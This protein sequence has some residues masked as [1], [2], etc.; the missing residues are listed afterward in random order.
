MANVLK[1]LFRGAATT[2]SSTLYTVPASTT[3][4][5]SAILVS[6][7]SA[8]AQ[9]YT[10]NIDDVPIATTVSVSAN[11]SIMFEPKQAILA[12]GTIKALA[13]ATSVSFHITG[14][15]MS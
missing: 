14:L 12:G 4:L 11:D 6:N 2:G 13:S 5:V 8:S 7:N 3:T 1:P 9:T 15:E 10:I